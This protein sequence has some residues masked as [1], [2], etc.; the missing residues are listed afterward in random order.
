MNL[1]NIN[2]GFGITGSFCT[3]SAIAPEMEKLTAMGA[4]IYPIMSFNAALLDTRFGKAQEWVEKFEA[5]TGNK[6]VLSI[7]DAEPIGPSGKIDIMV[8]AP[9]TA[10]AW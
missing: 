10:D 9:C 8:I 7:V 5:I 1:K 2:I 6:A 3:F 4:N